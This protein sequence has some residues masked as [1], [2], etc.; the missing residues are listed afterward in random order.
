MTLSDMELLDAAANRRDILQ[1][2]LEVLL[3]DI[4]RLREEENNGNK[5]EGIRCQK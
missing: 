4:K 3:A 1:G 2:I 5:K